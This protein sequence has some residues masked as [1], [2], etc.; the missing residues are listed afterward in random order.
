MI[1][2]WVLLGLLFILVYGGL[3][4]VTI[5][6]TS[7]RIIRLYIEYRQLKQKQPSIA[8]PIPTSDAHQTQE[9]LPVM[10]KIVSTD[11]SIHIQPDADEELK[12]HVQA[13]KSR[14]KYNL[15]R[16]I[17]HLSSKKQFAN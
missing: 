10:R 8:E 3:W 6:L 12:I 15:K 13:D 11:V 7:I 5:Y 16:I 14:Q 17:E 4:T 9:M 1:S 2:D